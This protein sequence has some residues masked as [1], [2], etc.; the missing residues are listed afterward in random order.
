MNRSKNVCSS[1]GFRVKRRDVLAGGLAAGAALALG[2]PGR[3]FAQAKAASS[4]R[5]LDAQIARFYDEAK[6]AGETAVTYYGNR[7]DLYDVLNP[8]FVER[9]PGIELRIEGY[10]PRA[11]AARVLADMSRG[12]SADVF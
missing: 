2:K 10:E 5:D 1:S 9:F 4:F 6:K 8:L 11:G 7:A 12:P 3:L